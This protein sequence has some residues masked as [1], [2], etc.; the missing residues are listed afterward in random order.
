MQFLLRHIRVYFLSKIFTP[1]YQH[2][3]WTLDVSRRNSRAVGTTWGRAHGPPF[4]VG[5]LRG[6]DTPSDHL[7]KWPRQAAL[8]PVSSGHEES[9][10]IQPKEHPIF[11]F[12]FLV[13]SS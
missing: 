4:V 7:A 3:N 11:L 5:R 9:V 6:T 2:I 10:C 12:V 13:L 8:R 1:S